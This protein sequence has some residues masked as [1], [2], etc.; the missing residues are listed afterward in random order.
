[1]A[2]GVCS[3]LTSMQMWPARKA[4]ATLPVSVPLAEDIRNVRRP[5]SNS[6]VGFSICSQ[7]FLRAPVSSLS[8]I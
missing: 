6:W 4:E 8:P 7:R 3:S 1:M 5:I 2:Y